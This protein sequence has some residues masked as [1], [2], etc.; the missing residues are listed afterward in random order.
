MENTA[1]VGTAGIIRKEKKIL[2]AQRKQDSWMEP[3]KWEFPGGRVEVGETYEECLLREIREEL[4]IKI[5]IDRLFMTTSHT[6]MRQG[7]A[8]PITLWV[9]L[10]DWKEGEVR[11]LDCQ[12][13]RWVDPKDLTHYDFAAADIPIVNALLDS[14]GYMGG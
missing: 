8:F 2:I 10:A 4:G 5:S 3:N 14:M 7:E 13:S 1:N 9:F 12:D 11:N 6:Y